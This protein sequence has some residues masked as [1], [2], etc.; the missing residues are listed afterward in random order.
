MRNNKE[1]EYV[2]IGM[3]IKIALPTRWCKVH[4]DS[5]YQWLKGKVIE[6]STNSIVVS[7]HSKKVGK[8]DRMVCFR[9]RKTNKF[10]KII[11]Q[12]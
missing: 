5:P 7:V 10:D 1:I 9:N 11:K 12:L 4:S 2:Y 6:V 8:I 3:R